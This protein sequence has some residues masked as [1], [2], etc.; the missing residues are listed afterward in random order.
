MFPM[1]RGA[2]EVVE[3]GSSSR[4]DVVC[5]FCDTRAQAVNSIR[6]VLSR[7]CVIFSQWRRIM[8]F[9]NIDREFPNEHFDV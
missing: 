6:H 2:R 8:I 4:A 7:D 1:E 3:F 9:L 5:A